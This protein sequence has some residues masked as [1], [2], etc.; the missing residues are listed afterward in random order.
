[1]RFCKTGWTQTKESSCKT[2]TTCSI[3]PLIFLKSMSRHNDSA[4]RYLDPNIDVPSSVLIANANVVNWTG[5]LE[6]PIKHKV[7]VVDI[8]I[9]LNTQLYSFPFE[10]LPWNKMFGTFSASLGA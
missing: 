9:Q 5:F 4:Q 3:M 6:N 10:I 2:L 7:C 8:L 1:M